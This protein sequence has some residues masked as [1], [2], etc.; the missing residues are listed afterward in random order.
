M[1]TFLLLPAFVRLCSATVDVES[2]R[3]SS[4]NE[5]IHL[6]Q[7]NLL[8][9]ACSA[10]MYLIWQLI[11][12]YNNHLRH[13]STFGHNNQRYF[14]TPAYGVLPG[15]KNT[16]YTHRYSVRFHSL[17][18]FGMVALNVCLCLVDVPFHDGDLAAK[19]VRKSS[20]TVAT[21]NFIPLVLM[22]GRNNPLGR[23]LHVP[24]DT[25]MLLH[26]WLGRIVVFESLVHVMTW[27]ISYA[28]KECG[29]T[30]FAA[31]TA[32]SFLRDGFI[33]TCALIALLLHSPPPIR[34]AFYETFLH[35]HFVF[36]ALTM[37]F[38]WVHLDGMHS[39]RYLLVA[40]VLWVLERVTR[41]LSLIYRNLGPSSTTA[42]VKILSGDA[43]CITL[44]LARP[45]NVKPGQH[46]YLYIPSIGWWTSHP[47][48]VAW[49]E[50]T[51]SDKAAL[52]SFKQNLLDDQQSVISLVVRRRAGMTDKVFRI[53]SKESTTFRAFIEGPY[54][55][56]H[57]LDSY[58]TVLLFAG[59]MGIAHQTSFLRHLVQG[60][61]EGT[62]AMRRILL[63]WAV[64]SSTHLEWVRSWISS[65]LAMSQQRG[66]LRIM[67]F[68][69]QPQSTKEIQGSSM[70][71][72]I[73]PGRPNIETLVDMEIGNQ[74][75]AMGVMVCGNGSLSDSVRYVCRRRQSISNI[76]FIEESFSW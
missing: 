34:H 45:W 60:H 57:S 36:A 59:G 43:M 33:A 52:P 23:I 32:G 61:S 47:F 44:R 76:D 2:K 68:V 64:R 28:E 38:L 16:S 72:P 22:A 5:P 40:I 63:V 14:A 69:T 46:I 20:G 71:V 21:A 26:R 18:I 39:Q 70:T 66:I 41:I 15:S 48:S 8:T 35:L 55:N 56:I 1:K 10:S 50:R 29:R 17:L 12:R 4:S 54:G 62:V 11:S 24:F 31:L 9:F 73:F 19:A 27:G 74:I 51:P 75:G 53:A 49:S 37:G 3:T 6:A 25:W 67:L 42:N 30:V 7:Y 13:L 65:I 58:G